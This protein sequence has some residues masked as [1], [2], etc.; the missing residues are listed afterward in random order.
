MQYLLFTVVS[1]DIREQKFIESITMSC[2][3]T[4][5]CKTTSAKTESPC[6]RGSRMVFRKVSEFECD[7][8]VSIEHAKI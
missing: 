2:I 4:K 5:V 6:L 1:V 8:D 3:R 7:I